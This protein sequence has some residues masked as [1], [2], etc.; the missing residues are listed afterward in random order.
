VTRRHSFLSLSSIAL[1]VGGLASIA[2][3]VVSAARAN[4][5]IA[6]EI[7]DAIRK[8]I[9]TPIAQAEG[10]ARLLAA[11][12]D[13]REGLTERNQLRLRR[14]IRQ[15]LP[16]M[17]LSYAGVL[18]PG[19]MPYYWLPDHERTVPIIARRLN[20]EHELRP[21]GTLEYGAMLTE[22]FLEQL[23]VTLSTTVRLTSASPTDAGTAATSN[24]GFEGSPATEVFSNPA[25]GS[26]S[27]YAYL[28]APG[29]SSGPVLAVLEL[30][31]PIGSPGVARIARARNLAWGFIAA[32]VVLAVGYDVR[33][34][35]RREQPLPAFTP[36]ANPYIVGNPIRTRDMF[37]GREDDFQFARQKLTSER[38][39]VVL[40]FCGERRSGK[41]SMLFQVL[42]GRLGPDFLPV[43]IDMQYFAAISSD[44]DFYETVVREFVRAVYPDSEH[45]A[46]RQSPGITADSP[47]QSLELALDEA[48]AAHPG[49]TF[50]F[51]FD[52]Y[53]I[54]ESKIER[55]ELSRMVIP[56]LAGLLER[57]RRISY[58][59]TGSRNLEERSTHHW[60]LMMGKSLYR[61]ISY[62]TPND[63]ERLIRNPVRGLVDYRAD[64]V[65]KIYRL[66]SGQPFYTQ[67]ICQNL[68]DLLN[69]VRRRTIDAA[70]VS[71][72]VDGIVDNPLPQMIYFWDSLPA[73]EKL[74]LSLLACRETDCRGDGQRRVGANGCRRRSLG[75]RAVVRKGAARQVTRAQVPVPHRSAEALDSP[76]AFHLAGRQGSGK[77]PE[78]LIASRVTRT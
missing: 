14:A 16:Q 19:G 50:L 69:E 30:G 37:F 11:H 24:P 42:D 68:I 17:N 40:V 62:L 34:R 48:M 18:L 32:L 57:K 44:Q 29:D 66:T 35:K 23:G 71:A 43:L 9:Y 72:I 65:A 39:G 38:A 15:A 56:Y 59:F 20:I 64:S 33:Q 54:L 53:E 1:V 55:E 13:V 76:H 51:L 26:Q 22:G 61:K 77:R 3:G 25:R 70:D 49:K 21:V 10:Q 74:A 28:R 75:P 67:V 27:R 47:A 58:I 5:A 52:E 31:V 46:Q 6:T 45:A 12:A 7:T 63:T 41:T 4:A 8:Y 36:I 60:R 2:V 73:E 78:C